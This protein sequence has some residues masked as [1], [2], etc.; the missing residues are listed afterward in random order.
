MILRL[1]SHEAISGG[2]MKRLAALGIVAVLGW[3]GL[4]FAQARDINKVLADARAALGGEKKLA[5][6]K[7]FDATGQST[8]VVGETSSQPADMEMAFELPDKFMKQDVVAMM[9]NMVITRTSGFNGDTPIDIIDQPPS[10][11][12]GIVIRM[13]GPG[14]APP[15]TTPTPEQREAEQKARLLASRQ[16]FARITLGILASSQ[17]VY[18]LTFSYGGLAESPDGTADIVDVKGEG[19]FAVR[20]FIDTKTHL[21]LMLSWM[22]KEPLVIS[23]QVGGPGG[24]VTIAR[25]GG[26]AQAAQPPRTPEELAKM[27]QE[28][29]DQA[30]AAEAK[31]RVVEYRLYYGDYRKVD[32]VMVPFSLQR[33]ID[34]KPVEQVTFDKVKINQAIDPKKFEAR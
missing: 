32:G 1:I 33:S 24:G 29:A 11:A 13:G 27:K 23:R 34:G 7:T 22:A 4:A 18:P 25:G 8:R 3:E 6:L 19:G 12:G 9:M 15:G 20:L 10:A 5:A 2:L 30:K 21:P 16:E 28:A 17:E 31:L 26:Q 14:S